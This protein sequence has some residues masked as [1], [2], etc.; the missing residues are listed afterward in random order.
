MLL[1][2]SLLTGQALSGPFTHIL[3]DIGP[4]K[5]V[6]YRLTSAFNTRMAQSMN[7]VEDASAVRQRHKRSRGTVGDVYIEEGGT[8]LKLA[9]AEASLG[10]PAQVSEL[11]IKHLLTCHVFQVN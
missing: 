11:G 2:L 7:D 6:S 8:N 10:V 5:F 4:D 9:E 1:N 3:A